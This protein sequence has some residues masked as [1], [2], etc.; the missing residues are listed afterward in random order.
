MG[1]ARLNFDK[2]YCTNPES[3]MPMPHRPR[4]LPLNFRH[5]TSFRKVSRF[6]EPP[7]DAEPKIELRSRPALQETSGQL[8]ELNCTLW[9]T[10]YPT[11]LSCNPTELWTTV[12][13]YWATLF[14]LSYTAVY[15]A[16]LPLTELRCSLPSYAVSYWLH[17]TQLTYG[18]PYWAIRFILPRCSATYWAT[19]STAAASLSYAP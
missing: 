3:R 7:G 6:E 18:L 5:F 8:T 9:A 19:L 13:P 17:F 16:T 10:Q 2:R 15:W 12:A 1:I 4:W 14:L 11:E